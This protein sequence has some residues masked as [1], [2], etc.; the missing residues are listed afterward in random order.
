MKISIFYY[1]ILVLSLLSSAPSCKPEK[2]EGKLFIIG[3][4]SVTSAMIDK[5][6]LETKI[7]KEGYGVI[8]PMSSEEPDS[9]I[10]DFRTLFSGRGCNNMFGINFRKGE[11]FAASRIDSIRNARLIFMSGGDQSR[12]MDIIKGTE[13]KAAIHEV[14]E[15][16]GLIGGYSAGAALMSRKMITGNELKYP[17]N[18]VIF[19][20]I[21]PDNVEI[22]EGVGMLDKVIIDQHFIKRKRLNRLITASIENPEQLCVGIDEST[23]IFVDRGAATVYGLNQVIVL[24]NPA[25]D[26][27]VENGLL[28]AKNLGLDIF[29]PGESFRIAE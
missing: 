18:P 26:I 29:L 24:K 3:G 10:L 27:K 4:G 7:D 1:S 6:I 11:P 9:A 25:S 13:V 8:L 23:A 12:F 19:N 22:I 20:N 14:Y 28:G 21:E 17:D 2:K 15:K 16:G 5:M